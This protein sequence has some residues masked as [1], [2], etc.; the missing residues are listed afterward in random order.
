MK[1]TKCSPITRH[2][3]LF[4]LLSTQHPASS[5]STTPRSW[6]WLATDGCSAHIIAGGS[7]CFTQS[8]LLYEDEYQTSLELD[9]SISSAFEQILQ[10]QRYLLYHFHQRIKHHMIEEECTVQ[11]NNFTSRFRSEAT[12]AQ[13]GLLHF[14]IKFVDWL[15]NTYV[16]FASKVSLRLLCK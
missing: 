16:C 5:T 15:T 3:S 8:H 10:V 11:Y 2:P 4:V 12:F 7:A 1:A 13:S 9:T 14:T 6:S